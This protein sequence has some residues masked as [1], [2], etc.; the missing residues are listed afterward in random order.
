MNIFSAIGLRSRKKKLGTLLNDYLLHDKLNRDKLI[1][2][3]SNSEKMEGIDTKDW[4][5][6][7]VDG[8]IILFPIISDDFELYALLKL[9]CSDLTVKYNDHSIF[10]LVVLHSVDIRFYSELVDMGLSFDSELTSGLT[11]IS[12]LIGRLNSE[13]SNPEV[14]EKLTEILD[15]LIAQKVDLNSGGK[16][17][18]SP[19]MASIAVQSFDLTEKIL[20]SKVNISRKYYV[21][22]YSREMD[23]WD[24]M[25]LSKD[26]LGNESYNKVMDI[27]KQY[28]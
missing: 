5:E 6:C 21:E 7:F 14:F 13:R 28:S 19:L 11:P 9:Y 2:F 4:A 23:I 24:F 10:E 18:I 16:G 26:D 15:Y 1:E 20:E 25:E 17:I 3:V 12:M 27:L 22:Q 8:A